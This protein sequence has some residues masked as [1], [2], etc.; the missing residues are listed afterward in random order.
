M[1]KTCS[2][3]EYI[4]FIQMGKLCPEGFR[5]KWTASKTAPEPVKHTPKQVP[6][7]NS[8]FTNQ[9]RKRRRRNHWWPL[10]RRYP[11]EGGA[12]ISFYWDPWP[13]VLTNRARVF[14]TSTFQTYSCTVWA[15]LTKIETAR[16]AGNLRLHASRAINRSKSIPLALQTLN[17]QLDFY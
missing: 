9:I 11:W 8:F 6:K 15:P 1:F 14:K 7:I 16:G 17:R 12:Q 10:R 2:G 13:S 5:N 4:C 3:I